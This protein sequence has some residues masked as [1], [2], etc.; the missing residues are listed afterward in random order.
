L[1]VIGSEVKRIR[2]WC[3]YR[4]T[5]QVVLISGVGTM[6]SIHTRAEGEIGYIS[7]ASLSCYYFF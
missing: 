3:I 4:G 5:C 2:K 1:I 7:I 6:E